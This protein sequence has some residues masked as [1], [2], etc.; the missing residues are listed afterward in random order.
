MCL[1][2]FRDMK[3]NKNIGSIILKVAF[4]VAIICSTAYLLMLGWYNTLLLDDYGF[5]ADVD[6]GGAYGLMRNA[7]LYWQ[8]RFSAFYV[9]GWMLKVWGHASNLIGYTILLLMLGYGSIYYVLRHITQITNKWLLVGSATLITNISVMAYLEMST[10]YWVCCAVYTLSTYAAIVLLTAIFFSNG[11]L[12]G[13]WIAVIITSL[14]LCG[15]A[16]NFTPL[17]IAAL[18]VILL[19]QM[20]RSRSWIFWRTPKQQMIIASLVILC[21]GFMAVVLG[22]G[23]ISRATHNGSADSFMSHLVIVPYVTQLIKASV[24]FWTRLL[25]RGLYYVLFFPIGMLIG[26]VMKQVG[27][28][29]LRKLHT[30]VLLSVLVVFLLI[31]L[32]LAASVFGTGWYASLRAYSFVS[33]IMAAFVVYCGAVCALCCNSQHTAVVCGVVTC[34]LIAGMSISFFKQEQPLVADV[35]SQIE[36]RHAQILEHKQS[37]R[38]EPIEIKEV[39]YPHIPNTYAIMRSMINSAL[40]HPNS[41]IAQPNEYFPYER[42]SLSWKT[43]DFRNRGVQV[44]LRVD[45]DIVGWAEPDE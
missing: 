26:A 24:V 31:E 43:A 10:F 14:Y 30:S 1:P 34:I 23:T 45:F 28:E 29:P 3:I 39:Q 9:L 37:G 22:P 8:C 18:G 2:N 21:A 6:E 4:V 38:N 12:W 20:I 27:Y 7:Y 36:S 5:V 17:V 44:Y 16:E 42:Y 35:R 13:R 15:G 33:F 40:G 41:E 32:S 19:T 11:K 25:S